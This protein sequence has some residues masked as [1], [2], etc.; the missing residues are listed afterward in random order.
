MHI[1]TRAMTALAERCI[2]GIT[3]NDDHCRKVVA[4]SIGLVTALNPVIGYQNAT[5]I[6]Q[7]AQ[8]TDRGVADLVLEEGLLSPVELDDILRPEN[9]TR[10]RRIAPLPS[11]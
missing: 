5:R 4:H 11:K 8:A 10:P 2:K 3:A 6:A 9:M 7:K 1:M